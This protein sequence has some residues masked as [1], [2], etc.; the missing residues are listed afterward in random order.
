MNFNITIKCT[1]K[2]IQAVPL[3]CVHMH[4]LR[5]STGS[6]GSRIFEWRGHRS[7]AEGA[8]IEALGCD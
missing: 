1:T 2:V 8:S 7:S 4:G 6:G 3:I 5:G